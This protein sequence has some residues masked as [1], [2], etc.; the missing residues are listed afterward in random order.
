MGACS[1]SAPATPR[2]RGCPGGRKRGAAWASSWA[3][4]V[5]CGLRDRAGLDVASFGQP[6]VAAGA[7]ASLAVQTGGRL[8]AACQ[9]RTGPGRYHV[10]MDSPL[11]LGEDDVR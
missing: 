8:I 9:W 5:A 7:P 4:A 10:H 1:D 2:S 3:P 6:A 11:D